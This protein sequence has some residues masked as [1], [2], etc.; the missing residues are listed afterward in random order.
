MT[1]VL[2]TGSGSFIGNNFRKYSIFKDIEVI[3]LIDFKPEEIVYSGYDVVLHLAAIV[4]QSKKIDETEYY[5]I[6]RDLC[7]KVAEHSKKSGIRHFIFLSTVKVYGE[8]ANVSELR[9]EDSGCF[10]D[11]AYG[12]SKLEAEQGL[13]KLEDSNFIVS[14]IRTPLVYGEG[15][16]ANMIN[17][18]KLVERLPILPFGNIENRRNFTFAENLVGFIDKIIEKRISGVFLAMDEKGYS[19]T[20]L[21][22]CISKSLGKNVTLFKLP[23]IFLN[24]CHYVFPEKLDR[25]FGSA[26]FDNS[27]TRSAL[28]YSPPYTTEEGIMKTVKYYLHNKNK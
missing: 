15:V 17:L 1:K 19:T 6:N 23:K 3:S 10:P 22:S 18:V 25:L 28:N 14:V 2:I 13:K 16:K 7:L 4:H 9:N 5:H 24:I 21:I 12:K 8:S 27:K 11:D 20:E 26:E